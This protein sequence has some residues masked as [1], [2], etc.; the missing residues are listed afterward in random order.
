MIKRWTAS[1]GWEAVTL[2]LLVAGLLS[3]Q[4]AIG[5]SRLVYELPAYVAIA[6][7]TLMACGSARSASRPDLLCLGTTALLAAYVIIRALASPSA[8][9]ARPDAYS[10]LSGAVVYGLVAILLTRAGSRM[11]VL[12][13]LCAFA[14][15]HVLVCLVQFGVGHNFLFLSALEQVEKTERPSGLHAGPAYL[16]GLLEVL[17]IFALSLACWSRWPKWA[18]VLIGYLAVVC[19]VGVGFTGSR[20][21]YL[22]VVASLL[23]LG[24]LSL[25]ALRSGGRTFFWKW[26]VVGLAGLLAASWVATSLIEESQSLTKRVEKIVAPDEGRFDLWNAAVQ[27]WN[28]APWTGTGSGTYRFYGR[29]FRGEKMQD[30]TVAVHNDYLHFLSEYGVLG[31]VVFLL[32]LA[33]HL[34]RGLRNFSRLGPQRI[35]AGAPV[36]SDRLALNI[37]ALAAVSAYVVHSAFDFNM[38]I[39]ANALLLAFVCGVLA[40]G[41][42]ET[43]LIEERT[44]S[45]ILP[46]LGLAAAAV[47]LLLLCIR[48]FPGEYYANRARIALEA[49]EYSAAAS[50]AEQ[51]VASD[52]KNPR[53]FVYLGGALSM[54]GEDT[55]RSESRNTHYE[56]AIAAFDRARLLNPLD[57]NVPL[58]MAVLYSRMGRFAEAEWMFGLARD[59][60]PKS[61]RL[62]IFYHHHLRRWQRSGS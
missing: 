58:E 56:T 25:I 28:L 19:Y 18:K 21:G 31:V 2:V 22:S 8:Y 15:A 42:L 62:E 10:C 37:G 16:A 13:P 48:L 12:A 60:H 46:K 3:L 6:A 50:F 41:G 47:L 44:R 52:H 36:L 23:V 4:V 33:A 57:G 20:G 34:Y 45:G 40:N 55:L 11:S 38:H 27:Q 39:P 51:A 14:L 54:I 35:A 53:A 61:E 9:H 7:A 30:D 5:G 59:R 29:L 17:G 49:E 43:P 1:R 24:L 32:F 26:S